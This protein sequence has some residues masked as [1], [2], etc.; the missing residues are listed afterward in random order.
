MRFR[1][2]VPVLSRQSTCTAP[3]VSTASSWRINTFRRIRPMPRASVV[4]ATVG[5][6]SGT[7]ATA[8]E[9]AV[10]SICNTP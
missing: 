5:R 9:I 3:S 1:V 6:P 8:S 10:F 4:V 7:A 2:S